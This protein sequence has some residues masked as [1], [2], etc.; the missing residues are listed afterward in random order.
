MRRLSPFL[1]ITLLSSVLAILPANAA[2]KKKSSSTSAAGKPN[3]LFIIADDLRDYVGWMGGHPQ[4]LTPN[5]D[6][7]AKL[8]M[9]FTNAHCNYALCNPSRTSLL[10]GMLPSSSGVFG[11]EQDWRRSVQIAGK[12]TMP[13]HF[14]ASGY[15]TAAAGKIFHANHGGPEGR[16]VGWHGG[17]R[18]FEQDAAWDQRFPRASVQIPDLPVHTGQ[19][20]N[21]L[22][23]W[24][25]DWGTIPATDEQTDDGQVAGFASDFLG[26][27][28]NKPFFLALGLYRPHSPWYVP[29]KYF[30][31]IDKNTLQLPEV[32]A[33]DLD[34]VPEFA[35]SHLRGENLHKLITDKNLWKDAVHAYLANIAFC[36]AMLGQIITALESGPHAKNTIIVFTSDHGWY[37][38]EKQM[39]HKGKLWEATSRIPLTILAPG[40]TQPDTS[41]AQPAALIDLYPTLCDLAHIKLPEHLDGSSLKPILTDPAAAREKPAITMMGGGKNTSYAARDARWR[42]IRYAD[43]S[44]EL[45]DHDTDPKEWSNLASKPEHSA[46]KT[47]LATFFP[48]EFKSASRPAADIVS[49]A[50][51]AGSVDIALQ[52]GDTIAAADAPKIQGRG[53]YINA[54]FDYNPETDGDSTLVTHGDEKLGYALH[55]VTSRPTLTLFVDGKA[56]TVTADTLEAGPA[57]IRA[58]ISNSGFLNIAVPGKSEVLDIAPFP[59][60][61]PSEPQTGITAGQSFGPLNAKAYPNSTPFDGRVSRLNITIMPPLEVVAKPILPGK[62]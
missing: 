28:Q 4:A 47:Q 49:A 19:N 45:Y 38:G 39:W 25:W 56:T 23:I 41:S 53:I 18:G 46:I 33:D 57:N 50:S 30:D 54:A 59:S 9:R 36:D 61:F 22:N 10:T 37:L 7:L 58:L 52:I 26:K 35:K 5:M 34:D 42:Y 43:G 13:E 40:V 31:L 27:R 14:K 15:L 32:K 8:G 16:L 29:Q 48:I 44:E 2:T 20:F 21:G 6:R 12:P 24:H 1:A 51:P 11:N 3:V 62:E 17:R 55:I 60:G